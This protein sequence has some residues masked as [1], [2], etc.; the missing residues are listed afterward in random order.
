M[1]NKILI[2]LLVVV[3][4]T[5][6][7]YLVF[8]KNQGVKEPINSPNQTQDQSK[9]QIPAQPEKV[10]VEMQT[11]AKNELPKDFPAD[12]P[13]EAGAEIIFNFNATKANGEFQ[14]SREFISKKTVAENYAFY[15]NAL[16]ENGWDITNTEENAS[17]GS[18]IFAEKINNKLNIRIYIDADKKV[19]VSIN[20][21]VNE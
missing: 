14:A 8:S 12:I 15:Q 21:I 1:K 19:R 13:L 10:K 11:V 5:A 9:N 6:A 17:A 7:G 3:A 16:K 2:I 20:N 18:L 4:V